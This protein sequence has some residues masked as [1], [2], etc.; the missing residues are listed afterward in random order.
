M[1]KNIYILLVCFGGVYF[2]IYQIKYITPQIS[3][4]F[5]LFMSNHTEL[6]TFERR[7]SCNYRTQEPCYTT[8]KS[9]IVSFWSEKSKNK[10]LAQN[11]SSAFPNSAFDHLIFIHDNSDWQTHT[12]AKDF[13]WISIHGQHRLWYLKRFLLPELTRG[14]QYIWIV[15]DD[16]KLDFSPLNYQCVIRNLSI[17][18]SA[19]GR[20]RGAL[21]HSITRVHSQY[22]KQIGRWTDFIETGP[23]VVASSQAWE[24][25]HR[26]IH[27]GTGSGWGI[28][29]VWCRLLAEQC[30][31]L[32]KH[33]EERTCA[34]LDAFHVDHQ[35]S[36]INSGGD[37]APELSIYTSP[38]GKWHT[39]M[40]NINPLAKDNGL[41]E[42]CRI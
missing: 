7:T 38:Y 39:K 36:G 10:W 16:A 4:K 37:G 14:Y 2:V 8:N 34:I 33:S 3:S 28:D 35:S 9:L 19:P 29:L 31:I 20:T 18:F 27:A 40:R 42:S 12:N 17:P 22:E 26:Y 25:L 30:S 6:L 11:I 15:D 5:I 13:I 24:C 23:I 32:V 41:I 1:G 21:S